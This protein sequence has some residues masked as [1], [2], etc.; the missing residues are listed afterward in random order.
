MDRIGQEA[1]QLQ[2]QVEQGRSNPDITANVT[3]EEFDA[4]CLGMVRALGLFTQPLWWGSTV[5]CDH[6]Q[7]STGSAP[8][9]RDQFII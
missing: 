1:T 3:P 7:P 4:V 6:T 9:F 5:L 2:T 8:T